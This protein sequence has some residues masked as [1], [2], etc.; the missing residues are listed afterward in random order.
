MQCPQCGKA[1][2]VTISGKRFCTN[3]GA[4]VGGSV[5]SA[6]P[7]SNMSGI[8]SGSKKPLD[9]R[10]A[11]QAMPAKTS[12]KKSGAAPA[13]GQLHGRQ[14]GN[15]VLDLRQPATPQPPATPSP[16]PA[17]TQPPAKPAPTTPSPAKVS[18]VT[19]ARPQTPPMPSAAQ[20]KAP[21]SSTAKTAIPKHQLISKFQPHPATATKPAGSLPEA[22]VTQ[23][24]AMSAQSIHAAATTPPQSPALQQALAAAKQSTRKPSLVKIAA[25]LAAIAIMAGVVWTQNSP[26]L[27]FHNAAAQVGIDATLPTY[28]PSSYH[29]AG[30][31]QVSDGQLTLN[32]ASPSDNQPL[33]ITQQ[34]SS[35]DANSLR[36]NYISQQTD[37]YLAVQGEG[38]TIYMFGN[39]ANWVNHGVWYQ[40]SGTSKLSRD[41]IIKIAY[42]L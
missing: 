42:G 15:G 11:A 24:D 10:A 25:A 5:T 40:I 32:F 35:W 26:K 17:A 21:A 23:V 41:Q 39:Q 28:I 22:V 7:G 16:A 29:Q 31:V 38:L 8:T 27:A 37:N 33:K 1:G 12:A 20:A 19:A 34:Q 3:C 18:Q 30:P 9:L 2:F 6:T 14:V 13:A 4:K 36:D